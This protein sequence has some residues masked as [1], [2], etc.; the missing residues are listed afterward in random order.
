MMMADFTT[1]VREELDINVILFNDG[2]LK[3]IKKEQERDDYTEYGVSFPNPNF[4]EFAEK[5]GG[6]GF[7][8]KDPTN[9]DDR[10]KESFESG[11]PSIVE[12]M[13]DPDMM[14]K[15]VKKIDRKE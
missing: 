3:N 10:L 14:A 9:L 12:V 6:V 15:G 4:A 13:V 8:V 7:R 11:K 2:K 5:A 1:A